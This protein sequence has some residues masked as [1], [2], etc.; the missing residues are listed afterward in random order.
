MNLVLRFR[1]PEILPWVSKSSGNAKSQ[2]TQREKSEQ[3]P[4]NTGGGGA[5]APIPE[6][7]PAA[8]SGVA[9]VEYD[10]AVFGL[11]R[12]LPESTCCTDLKGFVVSYDTHA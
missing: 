10:Q 6:R 3:L 8:D 4:L 2:T 12:A 5:H 9:V 1:R 11:T 7:W